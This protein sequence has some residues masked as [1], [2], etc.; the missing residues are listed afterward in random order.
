M[1]FEFPSQ[2][3]NHRATEAAERRVAEAI[4]QLENAISHAPDTDGIKAAFKSFVNSC[5]G[6]RPKS[7][8]GA[9][10]R[11]MVRLCYGGGQDPNDC[12]RWF[13][14]VCPLLLVCI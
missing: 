6:H 10:H 14:K 11:Y 1:L 9:G 8:F 12:G 4:S 7:S 2:S 3:I 13:Q 5:A